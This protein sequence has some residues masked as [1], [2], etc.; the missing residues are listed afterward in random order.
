MLHSLTRKLVV[1]FR[2]TYKNK[3]D[4]VCILF[5]GKDLQFKSGYYPEL[6]YNLFNYI[7]LDT[8]SDLFSDYLE[9]DGHVLGTQYCK[10][11]L[12]KSFPNNFNTFF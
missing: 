9:L 1:E 5:V 2:R 6:F 10:T 4:A 7:V 11:K 3:P 8:T 12:F